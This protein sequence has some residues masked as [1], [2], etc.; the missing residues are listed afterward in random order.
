MVVKL[1]LL[2]LFALNGFGIL[3]LSNTVILL[4]IAC[5]ANTTLLKKNPYRT[6]IVLIMLGIILS[7]IPAYLYRAQSFFDTFK[8][9]ANYFYLITFFAL[10][11][12][13]PTVSQSEKGLKHIAIIACGVYI[14]QYILIKRGIVFLPI[15]ESM[16]DRVARG[17]GTEIERFRIAGS[18]VF[19]LAFFYGVNKYL[20]SNKIKYIII[21]L[22]NII[23]IILMGF[24]SML[25]GIALF[26]IIMLLVIAKT[27]IKK[28][29]GYSVVALVLIVSLMQIPAVKNRV[30]MMIEKQEEGTH[31]FAN[32]DYIRWIELDYFVNEYPKGVLDKVLGSGSPYVDSSFGQFYK[33]VTYTG[34]HWVD[35]GLLGLSW[36]LGP[37]TVLFMIWLS[38]TCCR[39]IPSN[40]WLYVGVWFVYLIAISITT[41]E[42]FREGNFVFH[43]IALYIVY[44]AC[45][46]K[47]IENRVKVA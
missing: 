44:K 5:V 3:G 27:N 20:L 13:N 4:G 22:I 16:M 9:S 28:I 33:N 29:L 17:G 40:Q 10:L 8:A 24:R 26:S 41:K 39:L 31:T 6:T 34:I 37:F 43:S 18:G 35:W 38:L 46:E 2:L 15:Y 19:S 12:L 36:I 25:A 47:Q 42:Y 32:S 11:K 30:N 21:S 45:L 7:F 23:P 14:L 1:L